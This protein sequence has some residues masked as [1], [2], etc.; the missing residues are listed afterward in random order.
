MITPLLLIGI[1][2]ALG[3]AIRGNWS[4][5]GESLQAQ[6]HPL[7][8]KSRGNIWGV[9]MMSFTIASIAAGGSLAAFSGWL[10][11]TL[12]DID[13]LALL[14]AGAFAVLAGI[15]DLSPLTPWTPRRQVNENW[16]GRYRGWV[17]GAG[18]GA[19][20]GVGFAV[21]VM[22]WGYWAML[23]IA[24]V[25]GSALHGAII[26]AVFGLGRGVL[27][28]L[29]RRSTTPESLVAFHASMMRFKPVVF[30]ATGI[31]TVATGLL[32]ML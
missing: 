10:G 14:L 12:F 25:S 20:L 27:L 11:G 7:G 9:T 31:A 6:I 15:L 17:Y 1:I 30:R 16:I 8:E 4:P 26:G 3:A 19:Q 32:L 13:D 22:S 5:C 2:T 21:F 23:A 28:F 18:F 24:F 29:S